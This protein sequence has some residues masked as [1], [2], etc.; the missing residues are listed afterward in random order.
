MKEGREIL[1]TLIHMI[2]HV[3]ERIE[4]WELTKRD[5]WAF[6]VK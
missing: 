1:R 6:N 3:L 4:T 2:L 5:V